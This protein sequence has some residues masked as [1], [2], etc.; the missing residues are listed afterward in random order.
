MSIQ[1]NLWLFLLLSPSSDVVLSS[2]SRRQ[3]VVDEV[4]PSLPFDFFLLR[5]RSDMVMLPMAGT[6]GLWLRIASN[7]A[8]TAP[9]K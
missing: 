6:S 9:W 8:E 7:V 3:T 4:E 1:L 2:A 5:A